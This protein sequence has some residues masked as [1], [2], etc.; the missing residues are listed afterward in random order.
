MQKTV[1]ALRAEREA[2]LKRLEGASHEGE[3][4]ASE[5]EQ[6]RKT[7]AALR[8]EGDSLAKKNAE[9]QS[10]VRKLRQSQRECEAQ[11][12][13]LCEK[14]VSLSARS[15]REAEASTSG[16]ATRAASLEALAEHSRLLHA[17]TAEL[18]AQAAEREDGLRSE[19]LRLQ[20]W[21]DELQSSRDEQTFLSTDAAAPLLRQID[22]L[23]RSAR[24]AAESGAE[25]NARLSARAQAAEA[26]ALLAQTGERA[27]RARA[28]AAEESAK[29]KAAHASRLSAELGLLVQRCVPP[30]ARSRA[31]F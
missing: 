7:A 11:R 1:A 5:L 24:E 21:C 4:R 13:E 15:E 26:A 23:T 17:R 16:E 3:G 31:R 6:L 12:D 19:V 2:L 27:A 29:E 20:R 28:R 18:E 22:E 14:L 8:E 25:T 10:L 9:A 30:R